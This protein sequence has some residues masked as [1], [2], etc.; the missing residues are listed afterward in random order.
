MVFYREQI[1][2]EDT[3]EDNHR[4]IYVCHQIFSINF[5]EVF[6]GITKYGIYL[7]TVTVTLYSYIIIRFN[8]GSL[9]Q[10]IIVS[11]L[12]MSILSLKAVLSLTASFHINSK[13]C[14]FLNQ[15]SLATSNRGYKNRFWKSRRPVLLSAGSQFQLETKTFVLLIFGDIIP[16]NLVN[17]LLAF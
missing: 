17:L 6:A 7:C 5:N 10:F 9:V 15:T 2:A 11:I 3:N 12:V 1:K 14:I 13:E 16:N 8:T 4:M